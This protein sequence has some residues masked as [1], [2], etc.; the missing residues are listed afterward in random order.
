MVHNIGYIG[1]GSH[2]SSKDGKHTKTYTQWKGML[3]RC[4]SEKFQERYPTYK[5]CTV[6]PLW[7]NFQNF[8]TW[9][10][11]NYKLHM[12]G[13]HLDK[14]ILVKGNTVYSPETC[15]F[16]PTEINNIVITHKTKRGELPIG[17]RFRCGSYAVGINKG[18]TTEY[19]GTFKT[20]EEA[21][22]AYKIAKEIWIKEL[23]NRWKDKITIEIY[24]TLINYNVD[25]TD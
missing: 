13:W 18:K 25:I 7:H 6:D 3:N 11:E 20:K 1:Q 19:L 23:A 8:A 16:V 2:S 4:Y 14:D 10:D 21:F 17:V 24:N 15:G 9:F 12:Q 5:D 22:K